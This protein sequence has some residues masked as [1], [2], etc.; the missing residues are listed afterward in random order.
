M[1]IAVLENKMNTLTEQQ[2]L[3]VESYIEFLISQNFNQYKSEKKPLDFSKYKTNTH[4]W[5]EDAQEY[6]NRMR[7]HDRF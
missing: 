3:S 1:D 4:I 6:V 7:S 5:N 2:Q